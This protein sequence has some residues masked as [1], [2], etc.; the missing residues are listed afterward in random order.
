L[1]KYYQLTSET[2]VYIAAIVLNPRHKWKYIERNWSKMKWIKDSK[3]IM[4]DFWNICKPQT[5]DIQRLTPTPK[6]TNQFLMF[7]QNQDDD[8]EVLDDEYEHY[9]SQPTMNIH[10]VRDWWMQPA[11]QQLYPYLSQLALEILSIPAMSAKPERL[12]SAT[13]LIISDTR[14]KLSMQMIEALAYLKSWY[15]LK[16][17]VLNDENLFIGPLVKEQEW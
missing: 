11:Q 3:K 17:F 16:D 6:S 15:K 10:N 4:Q 2:P 9:C 14:N 12:F 8:Q 5:E 1:D 7:L 13:K